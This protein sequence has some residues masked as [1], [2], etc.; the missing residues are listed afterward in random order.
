MTHLNRQIK[1]IFYSNKRAKSGYGHNVLY[2]PQE[3][4]F[5]LLL[6]YMSPDILTSHSLNNRNTFFF[7]NLLY[8]G[9]W[10]NDIIKFSQNIPHYAEFFTPFIL[11]IH[12]PPSPLF[13]KEDMDILK[14]RLNPY[15]FLCFDEKSA[16]WPMDNIKYMRYGVPNIKNVEINKIK[17]ILLINTRKQKQS[18]ILYQ[19]LK[20]E[21]PNADMLDSISGDM[22]GLSKLLSQYKVCIDID[23]YYNLIVANSCGSYGIAANISYDSDIL[24][25][26]DYKNMIKIIPKLLESNQTEHHRIKSETIK[27]Y[28]W[29][30]FISSLSIHINNTTFKDFIV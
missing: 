23:N 11:T 6:E 24:Q 7:E 22:D 1:N 18:Y 20:N 29:N 10:I 4:F 3:T 8:N 27:K 25:V 5:D 2:E 16:A 26:S 13:K 30:N 21:F 19:Y 14:N 28:D 17:D 9:L 15:Y 12:S